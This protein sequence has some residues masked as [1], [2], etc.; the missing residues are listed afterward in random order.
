MRAPRIAAAAAAALVAA[1]L[2]ALCHAEQPQLFVHLIPHSHCDPGWLESF[3]GYYSFSVARILDN[4]IEELS[5]SP[6]RRFIWAEISFFM[7]W[8]ETQSDATKEKVHGLVKSGQLEFIG[9]G[10]VQHDEANPS[11][12]AILSQE[13][14]GHEYLQTLFGV[15]PRIA[16]AIDPFG[17]SAASAAIAA[18]AGYEALV[19][20]RI[21]FSLKDALKGR[22]AMEFVWQPYAGAA[23]SPPAWHAD[24]LNS[25]SSASFIRGGGDRH[26]PHHNDSAAGVSGSDGAHLPPSYAGGHGGS[27]FTH[28]LHTHYSAVQGFDFENPEGVHIDTY[29]LASRAELFVREF[30]RRSGAY[31][32]SHL[33]VPHGDDFKFQGPGANAQFSN[34]DKLIAYIN[35]ESAKADAAGSA[36]ENV[37]VRYSTLSEYFDAVFAEAAGAPVE[38]HAIQF[39]AAGPATP[40]ATADASQAAEALP[41]VLPPVRRYAA[42]VPGKRGHIPFPVLSPHDA[43]DGGVDFFPYADNDRSW[44]TGYYTTRP[45][46]KQAIRRTMASLRAADSLVALVRP[47]A[48]AWREAALALAAEQDA[49]DRNS[50]GAGSPSVAS[51]LSGPSSLN[52][53]SSLSLNQGQIHAVAA[54]PYSGYSWLNAFQRLEQTRLDLALCLHHDA[55]TGTSRQ[56]VVEDYTRRMAEGTTASLE[57]LSD[58]ASL[59]LGGLPRA[60][61]AGPASSAASKSAKGSG[62]WTSELLTSSDGVTSLEPASLTHIPHVL[63]VADDVIVQL[64]ADSVGSVRVGPQ[65]SSHPVVLYNPTAWTRSAVVSVMIDIAN[66]ALEAAKASSHSGCQAQLWPFGLV[67]DDSGSPVP[68]QWL[69]TIETRKASSATKKAFRAYADA[70][71]E[72]KG[73]ISAA[74]QVQGIGLPATLQ[75]DGRLLTPIIPTADAD[76]TVLPPSFLTSH[77]RYEL[78]FQVTLPAYS[79]GTYFVTAAWN[80]SATGAGADKVSADQEESSS[81]GCSPAASLPSFLRSCAAA[82]STAAV[83]VPGL[84]DLA[85]ALKTSSGGDSGAATS[86][87]GSHPAGAVQLRLPR[88]AAMEARSPESSDAAASAHGSPN[89]HTETAV[90]ENACLAVEVNSLTGLLSAVTYKYGAA[91]AASSDVNGGSNITRAFLPVRVPVVQ[92]FGAYHTSASGAYIFR[93]VD[94]PRALGGG[95]DQDGGEHYSVSV[96]LAPQ[97]VEHEKSDY[98]HATSAGGSLL[99]QVR[100]VTS[101]FSQTLRLSDSLGFSSAGFGAS[102]YA[103]M[104]EAQLAAACADPL[105]PDGS[106]DL[107]PTVSAET[108]EEVVML[109][110]TGIDVR[111]GASGQQRPASPNQRDHIVGKTWSAPQASNSTTA[112][113]TESAS[114]SAPTGWWTS[115]GLALIRRKPAGSD[116]GDGDIQRHYYPLNTL[117]RI[118][119]PVT[120]S[121]SGMHGSSV[122]ASAWLTV[123]TTQPFGTSTRVMK[124][125]AAGGE[126]GSD[127]SSSQSQHRGSRMEVM[128]HR[129]LG[130][131]D[132][133][134]L[135]TGVDDRTTLSARLLLTLNAAVT[136]VSTSST[137]SGCVTAGEQA[138]A[139]QAAFMSTYDD[140]RWAWAT[141][142]VSHHLPIPLLHADLAEISL[143]AAIDGGASDVSAYHATHAA[144]ASSSVL[145]PH[146]STTLLVQLPVMAAEPAVPRQ[147]WTRRYSTRFSPLS[148]SGSW[149]LLS[150]DGDGASLASACEASSTGSAV[151]CRYAGPSVSAAGGDNGF[152]GLPP[153][154]HVLSLQVRDAVT[155]DV[156]FRL[157]N[158]GGPTST[159]N[160]RRLFSAPSSASSSTT[161]SAS[162]PVIAASLRPRTLTLNRHEAYVWPADDDVTHSGDDSGD[163]SERRAHDHR[164]D[165]RSIMDAT[166]AAAGPEAAEK[167]PLALADLFTLL[168]SDPDAVRRD[169]SGFMASAGSHAAAARVGGVGAS[170]AAAKAPGDSQNTD[171]EGVFLSDAALE[172]QRQAAAAATGGIVIGNPPAPVP[173]VAAPATAAVAPPAAAAAPPAAEAVPDAI[174]ARGRLLLEDVPAPAAAA[175]PPADPALAPLTLPPATIRTMLVAL[176]AKDRKV[177]ELAASVLAK[178]PYPS[179]SPAAPVPSSTAATAASGVKPTKAAAPTIVAP[180]PVPAATRAAVAAAVQGQAKKDQG[181]AKASPPVAAPASSPAPPV[182]LIP[183]DPWKKQKQQLKRNV[184]AAAAGAWGDDAGNE[185]SAQQQ[186]EGGD[187]S[188]DEQAMRQ[189]LEALRRRRHA[190]EAAVAGAAP[191]RQAA[192]MKQQAAQ[193]RSNRNSEPVAKPA[194]AADATVAPSPGV[195]AVEAPQGLPALDSNSNNDNLGQDHEAEEARLRRAGVMKDDDLLVLDA[196]LLDNPVVED[197]SSTTLWRIVVLVLGLVG[198]AMC[199]R[200]LLLL[201]FQ[202]DPAAGGVLPLH[203][204]SGGGGGAKGAAHHH[205]DEAFSVVKLLSGGQNPRRALKGIMHSG[206]V[207]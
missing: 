180:A 33:L 190:Q 56:H 184:A 32:S 24:S 156:I 35:G 188:D 42:P 183:S 47:W 152:N 99:Q 66:P 136:P 37:R 67:T 63:P 146:D 151:A 133:R 71:A 7:R 102:D 158:A 60:L 157:Q 18:A 51:I 128:L 30:R 179:P 135:G 122:E 79:L 155:D 174:A 193:P 170:A 80:V 94:A 64:E 68:S 154:L 41:N 90:L 20:N 96:S 106:I 204:A 125:V 97:L 29:N 207:V 38:E 39:L 206:K 36:F 6:D 194:S 92:S 2:P 113:C 175:P 134:G 85:G 139:A 114:S 105:L 182:R 120:P 1:S 108:D 14:E 12:D 185:N 143:E 103:S 101:R 177:L 19:I 50:A 172:K 203:A 126:T 205:H 89:A 147:A 167:H 202:V 98:A 17:H 173:E 88:V 76:N 83:M 160:V 137:S 31:R 81:T 201:F 21:E 54:A 48:S 199:L 27:L 11:Y 104:S 112:A 145:P 34:L 110:E 191:G 116:V 148:A 121:E 69:A 196:E 132:G 13:A 75:V 138:R 117:T 115:D 72:A 181:V 169:V 8:L 123:Y 77:T 82:A 187:D 153:W 168:H 44:W 100:V 130:R 25:S 49:A 78:A 9:G 70:P 28:V 149:K 197:D 192:T 57:V 93:P 200:C 22:A 142:S 84:G 91:A 131:D 23:S 95:P 140:W 118:S 164:V 195:D 162:V 107:R 43:L 159:V 40:A 46:L 52:A 3:E 86:V 176:K 189:M 4:V 5:V 58:T 55:I 161:A 26:G 111:G 45:S 127:G 62:G 171:E 53:S 144:N 166:A 186:Q 165:I 16:Y 10:W 87:L 65:T 73:V 109:L 119:G 59:L 15:R 61:A 163:V 150:E 129:H 74:A 178:Y 141:R 198:F 124:P